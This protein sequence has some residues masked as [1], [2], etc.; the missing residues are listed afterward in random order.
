MAQEP[1]RRGFVRG[2]AAGVVITGFDPL[3][4]TWVSGAGG[5][6]F[7]GHRSVRGVPPLKGRLVFDDADLT[8]AADDFGHLVHHRPHAVLQPGSIGDIAVMLRFCDSHRIA[9]AARG[10]GHATFGQAQVSGGLVI[11]MSTLDAV[12]VSAGQVSVQA[13]ARW[14]AVL[15]ATL[16]T[17][18]TP[19]VLTDYLELSVGGTLSA[20]G[21]G[22]ASHHFGA[23]VDNVAELEV[24]TGTGKRLTCSATRRP[25]LFRAALAGLGQCAVVVRA[26]LPLL[27]ANPS[28]RH[29]VLFY[30]SVQ[31]LTADQRRVVRGGRFSFVEGE[32]QPI[33]NG[34]AG[35]QYFL[36]A[37]AYYDGA[38]PD[39]AALIGDLSY[40]RGTEQITDLGYFD[41]LDRLAPAVAFL[42]STG[43][44][45]D[46]HP[47]WNVFLPGSVTDEFVPGVLA[48][49]DPADIG[50]S[51]VIL[52]YPLRR[53]AA[54]APLLRMPDED[55]VFVFSLLKTAAPDTGAIGADAMISANRLLYEQ[56]RDLGG[57]QYP[58]GSIPTT[59][60]DW[61]AHFGA[62][63]PLLTAARRQYDPHGILT[64]GQGIFPGPMR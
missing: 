36:E 12:E 35:W 6:G 8:N 5:H 27:P 49:L 17:G 25:E 52:L 3:S 29:Y 39:D 24:V 45:F 47:W 14:S 2:L 10:Q 30:P 60:A 43:E 64:P 34:S 4:R 61:R 15:N 63:W 23:Q 46:P 32:V 57:Y 56:V 62:A 11:D 51:G 50:A 40:E 31:A 26:T 20:G 18:Q 13:G 1:T 33:P 22:G 48:A 19:P 53:P 7:D 55:L 9:A 21:V 54:A 58:V 28:V 38:P 37:A 41:F 44:W 16:P 42:Q 59:A